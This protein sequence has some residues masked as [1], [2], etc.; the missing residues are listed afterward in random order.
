MLFAASEI[1][2]YQG[3]WFSAVYNYVGDKYV[4][5]TDLKQHTINLNSNDILGLFKA[6][7]FTVANIWNDDVDGQEIY[8]LEHKNAVN[9]TMNFKKNALRNW[10]QLRDENELNIEP[11]HLF[12][13]RDS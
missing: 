3:S 6:D 5:F 11:H 2:P 1:S 7:N 9:I 13:L 4:I 12:V 10:R 8:N